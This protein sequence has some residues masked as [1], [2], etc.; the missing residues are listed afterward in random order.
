MVP[1]KSGEKDQRLTV[2]V[3]GFL[4]EKMTA[5]DKNPRHPVRSPAWYR[6]PFRAPQSTLHGTLAPLDSRF[7]RGHD[8]L[9]EA[10]IV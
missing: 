9:V 3:P 8:N 4:V 10:P 6:A 7:P 1:T 5:I 2:P